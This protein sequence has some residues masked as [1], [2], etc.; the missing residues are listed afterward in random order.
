[1][2]ARQTTAADWSTTTWSPDITS[3]VSIPTNIPG[4]DDTCYSC[5]SGIA[6]ADREPLNSIHLCVAYEWC[7]GGYLDGSDTASLSSALSAYSSWKTEQCPSSLITTYFAAGFPTCVNQC[8]IF[9]GDDNWFAHCDDTAIDLTDC[10][11]DCYSPCSTACT[12]SLD[13]KS[14]DTWYSYYCGWE[15]ETLSVAHFLSI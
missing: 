8:T 14:Y 1:L 7:D 4:C 12:S 5:I 13:S 2:I 11:C 10:F 6:N 3:A 9:T 15:D